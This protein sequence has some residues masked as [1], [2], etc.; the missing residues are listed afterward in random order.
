MPFVVSLSNH[1][2]PNLQ[3]VEFFHSRFDKFRANGK[4]LNSTALTRARFV[5]QGI[6]RVAEAGVAAGA[7]A[8]SGLQQSQ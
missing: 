2:R 4:I 6:H 1:E 5:A 3:T 8:R 7:H